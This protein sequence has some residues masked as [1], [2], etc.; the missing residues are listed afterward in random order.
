MVWRSVPNLAG[1]L[2]CR[3]AVAIELHHLLQLAR[4]EPAG[5]PVLPGVYPANLWQCVTS[6]VSRE[7]S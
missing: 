1:Q 7:T 3:E 4:A 5:H 6:V 2:V